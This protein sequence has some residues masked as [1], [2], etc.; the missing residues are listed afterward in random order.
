M[1]RIIITTALMLATQIPGSPVAAQDRW[2][3]EF[4]GFGAVGTQDEERETNENGFGFEGN[5]QYRFLPH[6]AAYAGWDWSN[7]GANDAI[8]GPDMELEE[9]G[10]VFGLRF[11]HPF[12]EGSPMAGW[13]RAGATM[14]HLELENAE[15]EI[16]AD[17][18]HGLGWEFGAGI[19]LP[20]SANWVLTPGIRYRTLSRDLQV[21][22][23]TVPVEMQYMAFEFG[24]GRR[25]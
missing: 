4:R 18:G 15:G 20:V 19:T 9:T 14:N 10:Y 13:L 25:F 1:N 21:E 17:S 2:G 8:A 12:R 11:E 6:M 5:L 7:F 23:R 22:N 16:V 3:F 24:F